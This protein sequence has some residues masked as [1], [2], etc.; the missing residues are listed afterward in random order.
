MLKHQRGAVRAVMDMS[1]FVLLLLSGLLF[2]AS[3]FLRKYSYINESMTWAAA[4]IYCR[5]RFTDLA[6]VDSIDDVNTMLKT[7]NDGYRGS[8]WIGLKRGSPSRW[9]WSIGD[10]LSQYSGWGLGHPG[11][12]PCGY[13]AFGY[14]YDLECSSPM[15][16]ACYDENVGN[17]MIKQWRSWRDAQIYCRQHYTDLAVIRSPEEQK[18]LHAI[19]VDG[20]WVWIGLFWSPW[21]WSDQWSHF[22]RNWADGHPII[23]NDCVAMSTTDSGKW[24]QHSCEQNNR[25]ICYEVYKKQFIRLN[26]S[27]DGNCNLNDPSLQ[28]DILNQI[29][30]KLQSVGLGNYISLKWGKK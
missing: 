22:F 4:Q 14:W 18:Q 15:L 25:F 12:G 10:D 28:T 5:E 21:L 11:L 24:V 20:P 23:N 2:N 29:R 13:F 19:F 8:V 30:K 6:T 16:F 3:G 17:I 9:G 27:C 1:L 26:L 7:V